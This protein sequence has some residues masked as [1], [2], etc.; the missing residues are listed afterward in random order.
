M[1]T[2]FFNSVRKWDIL[3]QS[4][5]STG[6]SDFGW[7][8]WIL[9]I[10][11][12]INLWRENMFSDEPGQHCYCKIII[13]IV[14]TQLPFHFM[15]SSVLFSFHLKQNW[16]C[17]ILT[18]LRHLWRWQKILGIFTRGTTCWLIYIVALD[19]WIHVWPVQCFTILLR[20]QWCWPVVM[21]VRNEMGH[22]HRGGLCPNFVV[23]MYIVQLCN[24]NEDTWFFRMN[25]HCYTWN[26]AV[27]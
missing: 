6:R 16:F 10:S 15:L 17:C 18:F 25:K 27:H 9:P 20:E 13:I 3:V 7:I 2:L 23:Q 26:P 19:V 21:R 22:L 14:E 12:A 4:W 8:E 5:G 24:D 1:S 11:A